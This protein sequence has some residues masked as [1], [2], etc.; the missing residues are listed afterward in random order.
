MTKRLNFSS[1][2]KI[3]AVNALNCILCGSKNQVLVLFDGHEVSYFASF[4]NHHD[5]VIQNFV[6]CCLAEVTKYTLENK[7]AIIVFLPEIIAKL[8]SDDLDIKRSTAKLISN[9]TRWVVNQDLMKKT[10]A[11]GV[12]SPVCALIQKQDTKIVKVS[13]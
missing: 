6:I 13:R 3:S 10:V 8:T 2:E 7:K 5:Q 11:A 12:I 1:N 9:S 4:L